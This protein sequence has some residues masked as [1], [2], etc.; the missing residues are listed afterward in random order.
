MSKSASDQA[1]VPEGLGTKTSSST[2]RG[3]AALAFGA[4]GGA[5]IIT[6]FERVLAAGES[7]GMLAGARALLGVA[8]FK[9]EAASLGGHLQRTKPGWDFH[10][11]GGLPNCTFVCARQT[12]RAAAR[13][14]TASRARRRRRAGAQRV[15][16]DGGAERARGA[17]GLHAGRAPP[18]AGWDSVLPLAVVGA[19][20]RGR[21]PNSDFLRHGPPPAYAR[22][23]GAVG[24]AGPWPQVHAPRRRSYA[25]RARRRACERRTAAAGWQV[26]AEPTMPRLRSQQQLSLYQGTALLEQGREPYLR[27]ASLR[28][29]RRRRR[30]C[31]ALLPR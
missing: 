4:D 3:C 20:I 2:V 11:R 27:G 9:I 26:T 1:V 8:I 5:S 18:L 24:G 25:G 13:R 7:A 14:C 12:T 16:A 31:P 23:R 15:A 6:R 30:R 22:G 28:F 29:R 19:V 21:L 10:E 17:G